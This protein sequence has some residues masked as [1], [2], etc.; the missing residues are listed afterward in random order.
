MVALLTLSSCSQENA[1]QSHSAV[2]D[3]VIAGQDLSKTQVLTEVSSEEKK[4]SVESVEIAKLSTEFKEGMS[5]GDLRKKVIGGNGNQLSVLNAK[6]TWL[7][8]TSK[9]CAPRIQSD[10]LFAMSCQS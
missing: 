8:M 5:Y 1:P 4:S 10:V 9:V 6:K 2:S 7:A 3:A